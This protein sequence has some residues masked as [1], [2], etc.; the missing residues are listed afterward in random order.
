MSAGW[1]TRWI[2]R[3]QSAVEPE[4]VERPQSSF[5]ARWNRELFGEA[6]VFPPISPQVA[7]LADS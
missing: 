6:L 1:L 4:N 5:Y 3:K 7:G 2:R